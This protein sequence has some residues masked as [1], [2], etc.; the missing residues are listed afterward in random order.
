MK[1]TSSEISYLALSDI[2]QAQVGSAERVVDIF[3]PFLTIDA[4]KKIL[5]TTSRNVGVSVVV[6]W[7]IIDFLM[8]AAS[9]DLYDFCCS[10]GLALYINPRLHLKTIMSDYESLVLGSAN[11]TSRGLGLSQ[12]SNYEV[13]VKMSNIS[14]GYLLYLEQIKN[15]ST[16]VTQAIVS[17]FQDSI[18]RLEEYKLSDLAQITDE[19]EKLHASLVK[20]D[21]FL[22]SELPMS[23]SIS[24]LFKV[25]QNPEIN[26][27]KDVIITAQHDIVKYSLMKRAYA[28]EAEF[29]DYLAKR[30]FGHSFIQALSL[31]I[32]Q[33]RR[34][35]SVKAWVQNNCTD[36]PIPSR[37]DLTGNVQVLYTWLTELGQEHFVTYR[38]N[39][40]EVISPR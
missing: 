28:S 31:F 32:N 21:F 24:Q 3:S 30:F 4:L 38:P 7:K 6:R 33:P 13:L 17:Q 1:E 14:R 36:V 40:S 19:D 15:E 22:I 9:L 29:R 26:L 34:F 11:V 37:R 2:A 12:P 25:V 5:E 20:R 23:K 35:G 10:R 39:H 8:G 16:I 27:E 18:D